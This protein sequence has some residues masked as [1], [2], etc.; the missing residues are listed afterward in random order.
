MGQRLFH[1]TEIAQLGGYAT[2]E[3]ARSA[4][5]RL[6]K[7]GLLKRVYGSF[8]ALVETSLRPEVVDVLLALSPYAYISCQSALSYHGVI[9]QSTQVWTCVWPK[10]SRGKVFISEPGTKDGLPI[11]LRCINRALAFGFE[12]ETKIACPEKALL[13]WIYLETWI[14]KL[15]L[16]D[17]VS[18]LDYPDEVL[19]EKRL[20]DFITFYPRTV[21]EAALTFIRSDSF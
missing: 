18:M 3:S 11:D 9:S 17:I 1:L 7:T 13:D 5:K 14:G 16:K 12:M 6:A 21:A 8:W 2:N 15:K 10:G 19:Q 4:V 20:A